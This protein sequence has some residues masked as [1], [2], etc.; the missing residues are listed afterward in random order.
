MRQTH[1]NESSPAVLTIMAGPKLPDLT[2]SSW[3]QD[4]QDGDGLQKASLTK[5]SANCVFS[6][7]LCGSLEKELGHAEGEEKVLYFHGSSQI[8]VGAAGPRVGPQS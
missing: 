3:V 1:R 4:A 6:F 8:C 2:P 7:S 5:P